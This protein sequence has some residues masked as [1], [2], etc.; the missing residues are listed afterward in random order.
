[1][2]VFTVC[3]CLCAL[4]AIPEEPQEPEATI[5]DQEPDGPSTDLHCDDDLDEGESTGILT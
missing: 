5:A 2:F 1:M 3:F 4:G